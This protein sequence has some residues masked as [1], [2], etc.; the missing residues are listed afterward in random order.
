MNMGK[1]FVSVN[2]SININEVIREAYK[3]AS[4]HNCEVLDDSFDAVCLKRQDLKEHNQEECEVELFFEHTKSNG[5]KVAV[6]RP[7]GRI[8]AVLVTSEATLFAD[9]LYV[10][11]E[12]RLLR[13]HF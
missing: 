5:W 1:D 6:Q 2:K 7:D 9:I 8:Q 4:K 13:Y 11:G 12:F 3:W 10:D